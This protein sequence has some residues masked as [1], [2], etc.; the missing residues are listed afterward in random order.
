MFR[1]LIP[2]T[3][4]YIYGIVAA[5]LFRYLPVTVSFVSLFL[6]A[7]VAL[8]GFRKWGVA[9]RAIIVI[10]AVA[11]FFYMLCESRIPLDDVSHYASGEKMTL[12]GIVDEPPGFSSTKAAA[13]VRAIKILKGE[14][15]LQVSGRVRLSIYDPEAVLSY[16]DIIRFTGRLKAI[17]G[18]KN[19]GLFDYSGYVA[20]QGIRASVS[21]G[22]SVNLSKIG[23]GGNPVLRKIYG[24]REEVRS[25]IRRGL[26]GPSSAI[27]QAM[28]IGASED[29][30]PEV[31]DQFTAAGVTHILSISGSHLGFVTLLVFSTIRYLLIHLPYRM[32]CRMSLYIIP[33]KTA[34]LATFPPVIFYT[35]ISGGEV[36]TVRSLI[37]ALVC[38][39]AIVIERDGDPVNTLIVAALLAL[40][41]D[42]QALFD[43]SFQLSYMAVFSM[44]IVTDRFYNGIGSED[45]QGWA[46][47]YWRRFKMLMLLTIGAT[48][49]TG[50]IVAHYY[51]QVT[52]AGLISNMV[53][54]PY[55]GFA[56]LP[57]GLL[58]SLFALV[59]HAD[60]IPFA[61]VNDLLL[62]F[63]YKMVRLFAGLPSAMIYTPSPG[64][65]F[66]VSIYVFLLSLLFLKKEWARVFF[67]ASILMITLSAGCSALV[68]DNEGVMRVTFVDVG[69]GDSALIEFPNREV[70]IID[71]GGTFSETFD[72]GRSVLAPYL[73]NQGIRRIDYVVSTH[74]QLDHV[75]GLAFIAEVFDIGEVW[76]NGTK[77]VAAR[78]FYDAVQRRGIREKTVYRGMDQRMIGGC[79]ISFL[80]PPA[81]NPKR[82]R[83][84]NDLSIVIRIACKDI[85]LLFTGDIESEG[86][87]EIEAAG[88][89]MKS[90]VIKV[91]HHGSRG[92]VED[93][94]ISAVRPD[95]AVISAGYQNSYH[96]P[97]AEAISAYKNAG[98]SVYRTDQDGAVTIEAKGGRLKIR[99]YEDSAFKGA[100][101]NDWRSMVRTE[102]QNLQKMMEG[103]S[104]GG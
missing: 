51:N 52:W 35:L 98:A 36:A 104:H 32:L 24:W 25:S 41:W 72:M 38:L 74:P 101:F 10:A 83:K 64:I 30:T 67:L 6:V 92:S 71:G 93:G 89:R 85:S 94:F 47:R 61:W 20:R 37:M 73:W 90:R 70:M 26:S 63:F 31:R 57:V 56:V 96:H 33:S 23:I 87:R 80:N 97:S 4:S 59:S 66:I 5:E 3:V 49:A 46:K 34:A 53:I 100:D 2:F 86:M 40:L 29:L 58:T 45:E 82:Q 17:R 18:F 43:I 48:V 44:I 62:R 55:V 13:P 68:R 79:R 28:V 99:R 95:I 14:K 11:G 69:Q 50:P 39:T 102:A 103:L 9:I 15:E 21:I 42:P 78:G 88:L 75:E 19:P 54:V 76:T 81:T 16:G 65:P 22:K 60:V 84:I 91:P 77:G 12:I 1:P 27:L 7:A 8:G